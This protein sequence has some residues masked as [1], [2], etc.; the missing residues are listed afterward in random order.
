MDISTTLF[1]DFGLI[2][3]VMFTYAGLLFGV[4]N[5]SRSK[6]GGQSTGVALP[7]SSFANTTEAGNLKLENPGE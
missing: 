7:D 3:S 1:L 5:G 4:A 2:Y 6:N